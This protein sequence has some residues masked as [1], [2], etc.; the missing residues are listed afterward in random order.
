M[1]AKR[2]LH[3]VHQGHLQ[4][5]A[6]VLH[7]VD[8]MADLRLP[9]VQQAVAALHPAL[10]ATSAIPALPSDAPQQILE[11]DKVIVSLLR[12]SDNGSASGPSG[13][14]GNMLSSLTQSDLC[15][16]GIIALLKDII[17]GNLPERA[18]QLLLSSRLVAL[19]KPDGKYRPIA[20][21]ELFYRLAGVIAVSK[22]TK[23]AAALLAPHQLGV[24]VSSGA[25][26]I[27]HSLQ[28]LLTDTTTK[29]ALLRVDISN[30]FNSCDRARVL[31][32]LYEQPTLSAMWRIA[33]FGYSAP[34][35]LL[36]QRCEGQHLLSSNGVRQGDALSAIL[37][38][39]YLRDMLTQVGTQAEV[40]VQGFFDDINISGE[41]TEVMK[42][43]DALQRLL[44]EVGLRFNTAK[45]QLAYFHEDEAPLPRS[46]R[47]TLAAHDVQVRTEWVEVVGAVI[48]RDEAAIR[49]G[50]AAT[51]G[52][53]D[54]SAAFFHRLQLDE[55][56]VQSAMLILRQCGVPKMN[57]ALRCTPPPCIAQH[58]A[59][60]DE[61]VMTTA[62]SKLLLRD[63][64]AQRQATVERLHA[65]L[66]HG[67]FGLTSALYTSPAAYLGSMAAV[68]CAPAFVPSASS[69]CPLPRASLAHGWIQGSMDAITDVS[70]E[71]KELLPATASSFFQHFSTRSASTSKPSSL[72]HELSSQAIDSLFSA[73]LQLA[74][75][76]KK[77]DGGRTLARLTAVSAPR[78]W[79]W[80]VVAPTSVEQSLS[81]VEYRIAS[82]LNLGLQPMTG[83]AVMPDVCVLCKKNTYSLNSIRDDPWHFLSC[84]RMSKGELSIRHDSVGLA[85]YH[86]ALLMGLR[87]QHEVKGLDPTSDL[88]PD[89]LLTLPG[90]QILTDVAIAH[91]LAPGAVRQGNGTRPLGCARHV[92][93]NKRRKYT[94]LSSLRGYEQ[95]PF[96]VETCGG[97]GPSADALVKAM[98]E[99]SEE[100]LRMWSKDEVIRHLVGS[101]AVSVQRGNALSYLSGYDQTLQAMRKSE[102]LRSWEQDAGESGEAEDGDE[103]D[104]EGDEKGALATAA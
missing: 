42:A 45:S 38:C 44:P 7:S 86:S 16:M 59:A 74:K 69:D 10:P 97:F 31:R 39:L 85:L 5:A 29:R 50:V 71:C 94:K 21:G 22:V 40:E 25:E 104:G 76:M 18:R 6:R 56:K 58:A 96:V 90:R 33:D 19:M 32:E 80:K 79:T 89:V 4:K 92:E 83:A 23:A 64:E 101:V 65:P 67:G 3:H 61:L 75:E 82:R 43:F 49:A 84:P 52:K 66:R 88:R 60:F 15:R 14:G 8:A 81:D 9:E 51:L 47:A 26:R 77:V 36:L 103:E 53:D 57:Y 99:A 2:A 12:K 27:V 46:I 55:L 11:D 87:V 20:V 68:A 17:N 62:T 91:P 35:Q 102:E 13:W 34:S 98:A 63:D 30:A 1:A 78:A 54:G 93:T 28:H 41:P 95:L 100:H 37:F 72:Q 73:S 24:G 48:G 70:P